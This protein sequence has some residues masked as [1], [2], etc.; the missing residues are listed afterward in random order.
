M[1]GRQISGFNVLLTRP[2]HQ[3]EPLHEAIEAAGGRAVAF[4]VMDIVARDPIAIADDLASQPAPD[5]AI[6]VSPNAVRHGISAARDAGSI[7]AIGSAT[8]AALHDAGYAADI[9]PA[10]GFDSEALLQEPGLQHVAGKTIR[11]VRGDGGRELLAE[12][13]TAGGARVDYLTVYERLVHA[14]TEEELAGLA[15]HWQSSGIDYVIVMSVAS[16]DFLLELLPAACREALPAAVLV[17]P[18]AR[19]LKTAQARVPNMRAVLSESPAT[20][21]LLAAMLA[22]RQAQMDEVNE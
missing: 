4:P 8:A 6:F 22:D 10:A 19:V 14:A 11:I 17:T 3:A 21:D 13:L 5:I 2:E 15:S 16:L 9:V 12:T 1:S 7:A 18:S 20:G